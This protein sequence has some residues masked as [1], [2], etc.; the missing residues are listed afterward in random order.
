MTRFG[1]VVVLRI[2]A[3][4][5][6][7]A[8]NPPEADKSFGGERSVDSGQWTVVGCQGSEDRR[9]RSGDKEPCK[10]D[11]III[12]LKGLNPLI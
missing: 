12:F 10:T 5:L 4:E 8:N 6:L 9:Q 7:R 3:S 2:Q 11:W 1:F